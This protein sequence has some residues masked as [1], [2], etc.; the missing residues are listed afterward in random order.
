MIVF[1]KEWFNKHQ[2]NLVKIARNPFIGEAIFGFSTFGHNVKTNRI[3]GIRQ[4]SV[5]EHIGYENG[6]PKFREHIAGYNCYAVRL[7]E[8]F[9]FVWRAIHFWDMEIANKLFPQYNL[10]FDTL[11]V[12]TDLQSSETNSI[13][14]GMGVFPTEQSFS[15]ICSITTA[16]SVSISAPY[17]NLTA[18]T[19]TDLF[20][21]ITRSFFSFYTNIGSNANVSSAVIGL[22]IQS[23]LNGL[24]EQGI[25]L[26]KTTQSSDNTLVGEDL[27]YMTNDSLSYVSYGDVVTSTTNR[28]DFPTLNDYSAINK[29]G[30][31]KFAARGEWE[32]DGTFSGTWVA[33]GVSRYIIRNSALS[34][35]TPRLVLEYT[36]SSFIPLIITS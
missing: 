32:L 35:N 15:D 18:G 28:F 7:F 34:A 17:V 5:I 36:L 1:S 30:T 14:R 24:G 20:A 31:S 29:T 4:N 9:N 21:G 19:T 16:T 8:E 25:H 33:S 10:G 2:E 26:V 12:Y 3:V 23:K 22:L 6:L 11:T 27:A 13:M